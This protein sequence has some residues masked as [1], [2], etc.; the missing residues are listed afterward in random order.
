MTKVSCKS[1]PLVYVI[2]LTWNQRE[3]TLGCLESLNQMSYPHYQLLLVDNGSVD[4]TVEAVRDRFPDVEIIVNPRNL[5][6]QGGFNVGLRHALAQGAKY[7]FIVN[8]DTFVEPN[9]LD[10]L[11]AYV[12][13]PHVGILAPKIYYADEP[14][15][16]WSVGGQRHPWTL[17]MTAKGDGQLDQGQWEKV[18]E[19]DYLVGCALLLKR[20]LLE[21]VGLFDTGY[22]PIYYEDVD[23][24]LRARRAG[25]R[26]LLIPS[27]HMWHKVSASGGGADSPRERYLMARNSVRFFRK[28]VRGRQWL[29][30]VPYRMGSAIKTTIRLL[31]RGRYE[32]ALAYWRGLRDGLTISTV[33]GEEKFAHPDAAL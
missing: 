28:H 6:F 14:N 12:G 1:P 21:D 10:E 20:S 31:C 16:I 15:R 24:C 3:D 18:L 30:I 4:G 25:Y 2:T 8:N 23:L 11:V 5:G 32:S 7:A 27:A 33:S 19:R 29:I 22:H 17:E 9:I 26:L 13:P